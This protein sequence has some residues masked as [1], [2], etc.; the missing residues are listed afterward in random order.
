MDADGTLAFSSR[1]PSSTLPDEHEP[2]SPMPATMTSQVF[3]ISAMISSCAGTDALC[4][5]NSFQSAAPYS[6]FRISPILARSRKAEYGAA[7]WKLFHKHNAS[8]IG[9]AHV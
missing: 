2:Q 9:R 8:E 7:D 4:L 3:R 1:I 6:A 5:W